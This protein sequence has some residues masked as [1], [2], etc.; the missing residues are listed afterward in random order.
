MTPEEILALKN[1]VAESKKML[2]DIEAKSLAAIN[3]KSFTNGGAQPVESDVLAAFGTSD[4]KELLSLNLSEF[5][6][7]V[8]KP[9]MLKA[10]KIKRDIDISRLHA[11]FYNHEDLGAMDDR[12]EN[13]AKICKSFLSNK[14]A[15]ALKLEQN[16]KAYGTTVATGGLEYIQTLQSSNYMSEFELDFKVG[17]LFQEMALPTK[18][19]DF[20]ISSDPK[21]ARRIAEG[22][23]AVDQQ[24]FKTS[25]ISFTSEKWVSY[26]EVP[27]ELDE[28]SA[29]PFLTMARAE[30]IKAHARSL[31]D[32]ILNGDNSAVHMDAGVTALIDTETTFKG[33]RKLALDNSATVNFA[34]AGP[35]EAKI[36]ELIAK[37]DRFGVNP[38]DCVFIMNSV[39]YAKFKLLPGVYTIE[40]FGPLAT[41][42]KGTLASY[43]GIPIVVSNVMSKTMSA[44][45]VV[46]A[47][48]S[49]TSVIH[50]VNRSRFMIGMRRPL[51]LIVQRD[52][53][54]EYDRSQIAAYQR[55]D[56]KG[57]P[58]SAKELS[59]VLGIN[60]LS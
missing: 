8:E 15:L 12:Y 55:L 40:K 38:E 32:A 59:T 51:K 58:Q 21:K 10:M 52:P 43:M 56:F 5:A 33:L 13:N 4:L 26:S 11:A 6:H 39:T 36:N 41:V 37:A 49:T 23:A 22:A 44:A 54:A 19:Y 57:Y 53:R 45:G 31:E 27:E 28:D 42:I 20:S 60:V 2:A 29:V 50:L 46:P 17:A 3:N 16:L 25:K 18:N 35:T 1:Q 30:A 9:M 7:T 48:A 24:L 14:S 47:V 34:G